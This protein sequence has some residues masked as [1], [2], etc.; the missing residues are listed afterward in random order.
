MQTHANLPIA[1]KGTFLNWFLIF[2]IVF[3]VHG[4]FLVS[5]KMPDAPDSALDK[6]AQGIHIG[7]KNLR[8]APA[9]LARNT[10]DNRRQTTKPILAKPSIQ[11]PI[12]SP[13]QP[14]IQS[15]IQPPIQSQK[16]NNL[17]ASRKK[18][19]SKKP[20][21]Q[22]PEP[23]QTEKLSEAAK[24]LDYQ[25]AKLSDQEAK[26]SDAPENSAETTGDSDN[27]IPYEESSLGGGDPAAQIAY[28]D[29]LKLWL[30]KHKI[31]P[32]SAQR[33]RQEAIIPF[34]LSI[35]R[36]GNL[37]SYKIL[38]FSKF[39]LLNKSLGKILKRA[40]PFPSVPVTIQNNKTVFH[41]QFAI[42]FTLR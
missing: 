41:Y 21:L 29:Q 28:E 26:L 40:S 18:F 19:I 9:T 32:S 24:P 30:E 16:T 36:D 1:Y 27:T 31:Y 3:I 34:E 2:S 33:R 23:I 22:K 4:I 5:F 42:E 10:P 8:P 38:T 17:Q 14:P 12:Q 25:E 6:G 7:L 15:P 11:S 35:D 37:V 39:N 13:I 20:R